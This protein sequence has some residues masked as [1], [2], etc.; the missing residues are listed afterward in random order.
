L[1]EI[2]AQKFSLSIPLYVKRYRDKDELNGEDR[3]LIRLVDQWDQE[4]QAFWQEMDSLFKILDE[5]ISEGK[6]GS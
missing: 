6:N 4:G 2:T 1:E 5:V 3:Q